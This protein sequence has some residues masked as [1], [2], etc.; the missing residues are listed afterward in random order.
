MRMSGGEIIEAAG[1]AIGPNLA[2]WSLCE[3]LTLDGAGLADEM[4]REVLGLSPAFLMVRRADHLAMGGFWEHL[5]MYGDEP[6]YALRL[7]RRGK[8]IL[9]PGSRM[10]H[11]GGGASGGH[12]S[13]LR[14][15]QSS[16]NRLLNAARHL[17]AGRLLAAVGLSAGFDALQVAQQRTPEARRAVLRGWRDGLLGMPA[18][19][20]LSTRG[21]RRANVALLS[22]LG[23]A[24]RQQRSLGRLRVGGA[25]DPGWGRF[26]TGGGQAS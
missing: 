12:Q 22:S 11:W 16:R 25:S 15:Y 21:E 26:S 18:A 23:D 4:P 14:L 10:R 20:R 1:I 2:A 13:P 6:D 5:W 19:R 9:C 8:A 17:P 3:G 7:A 24:L